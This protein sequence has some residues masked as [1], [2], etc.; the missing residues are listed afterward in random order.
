MHSL[1]I[2]VKA[3]CFPPG[4]SGSG[5]VKCA[6]LIDESFPNLI[7]LHTEAAVGIFF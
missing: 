6:V 7:G 3:E 5:N 4:Q 2:R 1:H